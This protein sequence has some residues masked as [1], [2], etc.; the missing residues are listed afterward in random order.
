MKIVFPNAS[1]DTSANR[2]VNL[3]QP[4]TRPWDHPNLARG[5]ITK[6]VVGR[7]FKGNE[8]RCPPHDNRCVLRTRLALLNGDLKRY[9]GSPR[10]LPD[11]SGLIVSTSGTAFG[12]GTPLHDALTLDAVECCDSC[13]DCTE[14]LSLTLKSALSVFALRAPFLDAIP[15]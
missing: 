5:S 15:P 8:L 7:R 3:R 10:R 11:Q 9:F 2:G 12:I 6:L 1:L 4:T 14:Q 13:P